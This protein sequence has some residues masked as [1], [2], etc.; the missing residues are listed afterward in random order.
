[1]ENETENRLPILELAWTRYAHFDA[2]AGGRNKSHMTFRKRIA[3]L[4]VLATLFAILTQIYSTI[5]VFFGREI[6]GFVLKVVFIATP[7]AASVLA[8]YT[9][10]SFGKGD[11][12]VMRAGAEE[13]LKDIFVFR[14]ILQNSPDRRAWLEK[15]LADI[16]R[17]VYRGLGGE[18]I[19]KP[20]TGPIPPY[21]D[22]S[23]PYDDAG[24]GDLTGD[25]YFAFRVESQLGW[26][27]KKVNQLQ[28]ERN[29]LQIYIY[30]FGGLGALLAAF[31]EQFGISLWVALTASIVAAMTGW[32]ELRNLD[33]V[34]KN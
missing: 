8:A 28:A 15:K 27:M 5:P 4:G 16:Q 23:D 22:P 12:L 9:N 30:L 6:L 21:D 25:Q 33:S 2:A 11:W 7:I 13:I 10:W 17:N 1:M 24:F 31:G 19:L 3:I 29:R 26:H 32:Q 14:T 18:M 34:I 20:Y